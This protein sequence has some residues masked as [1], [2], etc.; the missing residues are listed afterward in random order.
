MAAC[1]NTGSNPASQARINATIAVLLRANSEVNVPA[2]GR[3]PLFCAIEDRNEE[4]IAML[5]ER[6]A[7]SFETAGRKLERLGWQAVFTLGGH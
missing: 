6:D 1:I 7:R 5:R 4:L 2:R 3:S